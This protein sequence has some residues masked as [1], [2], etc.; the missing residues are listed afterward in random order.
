MAGA[1]VRAIRV[2]YAGELGWELYVPSADARGVW[3]ALMA[4]DD[5]T[6]ARLLCP[7][8]AEDREGLPGVGARAHAGRHAA[9]GGLG[10]TVRLDKTGLHRA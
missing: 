10:F 3:D 2:S 8:L 6:P 7:R 9:S 4:G 1:P 5:V